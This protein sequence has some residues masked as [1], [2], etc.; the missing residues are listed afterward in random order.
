MIH[1][2]SYDREKLPDGKRPILFLH[3]ST[4]QFNSYQSDDLGLLASNTARRIFSS[5]ILIHCA[6]L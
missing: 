1:R 2:H 4:L 6:A 5:S 3:D